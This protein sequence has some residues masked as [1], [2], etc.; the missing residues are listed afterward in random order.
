[1]IFGRP[2]TLSLPSFLRKWLLKESYGSA[3]V[4]FVFAGC[5][6]LHD[7]AAVVAADWLY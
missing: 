1:M 3:L 6:V 7:A 2:L 5:E 4:K